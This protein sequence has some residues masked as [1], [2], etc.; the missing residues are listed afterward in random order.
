MEPYIEIS[1]LSRTYKTPA[2]DFPA[3]RGIDIRFDLGELVAV[4]GKS[5]SGK[6]TFINCL[7]GTDNPSSGSIRIGDT[8]LEK[9]NENQ[10]AD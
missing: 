4:I 7:S 10:M 5:G 8:C 6:S 2:G 3:L 1:G 9:L